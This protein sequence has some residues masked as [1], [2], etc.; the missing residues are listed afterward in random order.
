[1]HVRSCLPPW[2]LFVCLAL[3]AC[4]GDPEP[5]PTPETAPPDRPPATAPQQPDA[6]ATPAEPARQPEP[7]PPRSDR[8]PPPREDDSRAGQ[9]MAEPSIFSPGIVE[10]DPATWQD[11]THGAVATLIY[12]TRKGDRQDADPMALVFSS[13]PTHRQFQRR[14]S[15]RVSVLRFK[16]EGMQALLA[17]LERDGLSQL[18]WAPQAYDETVGPERALLLYRDGRRVRVVK[19]ELD[20]RQLQTFSAIERRLIRVTM[21]R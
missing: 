18:P 14:D 2:S 5:R 6:P 4:G 13:D 16:K 20:P 1:M 19:G 12:V 7:T 8:E 10:D 15:A 21:D 11:T 17:Q 9:G 3:C